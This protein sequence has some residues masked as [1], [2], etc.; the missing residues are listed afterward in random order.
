MRTCAYAYTHNHIHPY[1][2]H[3]LTGDNAYIYIYIYIYII[4]QRDED[5][6]ANGLDENIVMA[7]SKRMEQIIK[8]LLTIPTEKLIDMFYDR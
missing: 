8:K 5:G 2:P 6:N 4:F 7:R 1:T 3:F